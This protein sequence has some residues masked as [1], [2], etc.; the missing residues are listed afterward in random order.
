M[1][2]FGYAEAERPQQCDLCGKIN[3]LR[4]YGPKGE[5]VCFVCAMRDAEAAK[6]R[7]AQYLFG[8]ETP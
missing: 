1:S 2:G 5:M 3:E 7:M 6:K 8:K 4:P